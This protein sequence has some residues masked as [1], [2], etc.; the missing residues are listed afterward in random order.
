MGTLGNECAIRECEG[1]QGFAL[2]HNLEMS[3]C[4]KVIES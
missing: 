3:V 1:F 4:E 2:H